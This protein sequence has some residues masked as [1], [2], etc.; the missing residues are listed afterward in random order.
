[1]TNPI[2]HLGSFRILQSHS[3]NL[4]D[5]STLFNF[6]EH[7]KIDDCFEIHN[8]IKEKIKHLAGIS[9][10]SSLSVHL[11]HHGRNEGS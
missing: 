11:I 3:A 4:F 1:M 10:L 7:Y 8:N 6:G 2:L 5:P 9:L